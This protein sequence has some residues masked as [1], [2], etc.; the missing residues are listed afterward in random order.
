ML[1][2]TPLALPVA[3]RADDRGAAGSGAWVSPATWV[4]N[5]VPGSGDRVFIGSTYPPGAASTATVSLTSNQTALAVYLGIGTGTAGTLQLGAATLTTQALVLGDASGG[6][7]SVLRTTGTLAVTGT[8]SVDGTGGN[9]FTF[10]AGDTAA[11]LSLVNGGRATTTAAGNIAGG[12]VS[13]SGS[14]SKL[15][16]GANLVAA[17]GYTGVSGGGVIDAQG[18]A[19]TVNRLY[20]DATGSLLNRGAITA[21]GLFVAGQPFALTPADSVGYFSLSGA[22]ATTTLGAGVA[23][24][25]LGLDGGATATTTAAGNIANNVG[26]GGAGSKLTLGANLG[27]SDTLSVTDGGGLD[28]QGRNISAGYA[29]QIGTSG[30]TAP[31]LQNLGTVTTGRFTQTGGSTV[32]LGAG[33]STIRT[34]ALSQNSTLAVK[35]LNGSAG[36]L[37]VSG[38]AAGD[39]SVEAGSHLAL[40]LDGTLPGQYA[41]RWADPSGGNHVADINGLISSGAITVGLTNGAQY[42]VF[43]DGNYSYVA[44]PVPEPAAAL[45]SGAAAAA[46]TGLVRRKRSLRVRV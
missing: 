1:A 9:T 26:V 14:G 37:T 32:T 36:R 10:A 44:V 20:L 5:T 3:A 30:G 7:A 19:L 42:T 29:V 38:T 25:A 41:L 24:S 31:I 21:N 18:H 34:V 33:V 16:L 27:I 28:A 15:T 4:G 43:S 12:S 17:D 46:V 13:V 39:L 11:N 45:A 22:A 35:L 23:V 8:L 2:V 40:T 6:T